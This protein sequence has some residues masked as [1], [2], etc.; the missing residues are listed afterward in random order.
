M[1]RIAPFYAHSEATKRAANRVYHNNRPALRAIP[2]WPMHLGGEASGPTHRTA[3][4]LPAY[5]TL[6][7]VATVLPSCV[8]VIMVTMSPTRTSVS[9]HICPS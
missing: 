7:L 3:A 6:I 2:S 4:Y 5:F 1:S 9:A 8:S